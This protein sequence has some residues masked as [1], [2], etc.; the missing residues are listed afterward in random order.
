MLYLIRS[1]GRGKRTALK[2]GFTDNKYQRFNTYKTENPFFEVISIRKGTL[3]TEKLIHLYLTSLG[4]K[5]NFLDEWFLDSNDVLSNFHNNIYKI[6]KQV[7]KKRDSLFNK[8]DLEPFTITRKIYD[9]LQNL[10]GKSL[11][12]E[13]DKYWNRK[14]SK[15]ILSTIEKSYEFGGSDNRLK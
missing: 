1:F 15:E 8:T 13:I 10:F 2:V 5:E 7:W 3:E 11:Y 9:D 4:L 14:K 6:K 12:Y